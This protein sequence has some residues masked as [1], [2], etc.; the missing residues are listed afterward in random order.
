MCANNVSKIKC[1]SQAFFLYLEK[2]NYNVIFRRF[3]QIRKNAW[4]KYFNVV[5][6]FRRFFQMEKTPAEKLVVDFFRRF[7]Q[8]RK[9]A[10]AVP[11]KYF[12]PGVFSRH[13]LVFR[14]KLSYFYEVCWS[15][16]W[17]ILGTGSTLFET[18][19]LFQIPKFGEFSEISME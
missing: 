19:I 16:L 18:W 10:P 5:E 9:S 2:N 6:I 13:A 12:C 3:F 11:A 8:I 7:F 14:V 15:Y 17:A 4:E 1:F